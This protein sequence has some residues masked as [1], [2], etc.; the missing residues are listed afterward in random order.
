MH[1]G[2][3]LLAHATSTGKVLLVALNLQKQ[4]KW[5]AN[6]GLKGLAPYTVQDGT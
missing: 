4:K 3:Q 5:V 2:T 1:L 6:Y